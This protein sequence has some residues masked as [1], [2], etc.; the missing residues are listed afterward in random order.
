[1]ATNSGVV[2][3]QAWLRSE[4][5][6]YLDPTEHSVDGWYFMVRGPRFYGPFQSRH[7]ADKVLQRVV[8]G[9]LAANCTSGR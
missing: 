1:M 8:N 9:Y 2:R 7:E 4:R 3:R 5:L 6:F